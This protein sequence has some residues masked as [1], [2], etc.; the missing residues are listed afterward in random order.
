VPDA[1]SSVKT[2]PDFARRDSRAHGFGG[3]ARK[4]EVTLIAVASD[5]AETA[6]MCVIGP[7]ASRAGFDAGVKPTI[8]MEIT[9]ASG[10]IVRF[11]G[12]SQGGSG[13]AKC[14]DVGGLAYANARC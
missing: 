12:T 5:T 8:A 1:R 10:A 9:D 11:N 4:G 2:S 3:W 14:G 13:L 7:P 6:A